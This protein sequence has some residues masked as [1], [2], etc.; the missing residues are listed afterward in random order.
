[1]QVLP[2]SVIGQG[3]GMT[4]TATMIAFLQLDKQVGTL[5]CAGILLPGMTA[6]VVRPDGT[7][8]GFSEPGELHL[9]SA[10]FATG[11]F[12]N[13][14]ASAETFVDGSAAHR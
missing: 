11:Y 3:Y 2:K 4:K 14:A 10:A 6:R 5:G 13:S 1:M 12:D 7:L 9:R 8:A